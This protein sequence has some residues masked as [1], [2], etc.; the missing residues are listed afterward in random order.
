MI[1]SF[2]RLVK[3]REVDEMDAFR[4][5]CSGVEDNFKDAHLRAPTL[6]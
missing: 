5:P 6:G 2:K 1:I 4:N 3:E